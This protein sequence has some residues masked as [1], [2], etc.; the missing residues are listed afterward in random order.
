[1]TDPD[2][3]VPAVFAHAQA[4]AV[5]TAPQEQASDQDEEGTPDGM[6]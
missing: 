3:A 4:A 1:M 5:S 2:G 6:D